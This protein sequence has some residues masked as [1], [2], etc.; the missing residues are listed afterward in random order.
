MYVVLCA[1][2]C[3]S[4]FFFFFKK[5]VVQ[6]VSVCF[7]LVQLLCVVACW[8]S[9]VLFEVFFCSCGSVG[10]FVRFK[11]CLASATYF[12]HDRLW[13]RSVLGIFEAEDGR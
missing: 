2:G 1:R 6:S 10:C 7:K 12:G 9:R 11:G 8:Q 3:W 4:L 5:K 13:P